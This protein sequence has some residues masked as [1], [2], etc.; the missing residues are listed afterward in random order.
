MRKLSIL[1]YTFTVAL[2]TAHIG[3]LYNQDRI[4]NLAVNKLTECIDQPWCDIE[5]KKSNKLFTPSEIGDKDYYPPEYE[6]A[7]NV[8]IPPQ[9]PPV[10]EWVLE[11]YEFNQQLEESLSYGIGK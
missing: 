5:P 1:V 4:Y 6:V 7:Q 3:E 11:N 10:P 2:V 8:P 9:K